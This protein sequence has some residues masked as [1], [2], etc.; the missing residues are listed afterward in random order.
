LRA[1]AK[2]ETAHS[3]SRQRGLDL[4]NRDGNTLLRFQ[5]GSKRR[6]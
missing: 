1:P 6:I 3:A 2:T 4:T 5:H